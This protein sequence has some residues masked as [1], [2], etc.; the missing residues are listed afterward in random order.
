M[1]AE[2]LDIPKL[3]KEWLI[4][5]LDWSYSLKRKLKFADKIIVV[6]PNLIDELAP[7]VENQEKFVF[8]PNGVDLDLFKPADD[9]ANLRHKL[10]LPER[11]PVIGVVGSML[12]YHIESPIINA[13]EL[14]VKQ[15]PELICLFVG[16]GPAEE[17]IKKKVAKSKATKNIR[18]IGRVPVEQSAKY[19]ATLDV[20]LAWS[21][22]ESAINGWPMRISAY[23]ACGVP[24]VAPDWGCYQYCKNKGSLLTASDGTAKA[25]AE[26]TAKILNNPE[27]A[28]KIGKRARTWAEDELSWKEIT[29]KTEKIIMGIRRG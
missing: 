26:T 13:I 6:S 11:T 24:T 9:K 3:S 10:D 7:K 15:F 21:T 28:C 18:I 17:Q 25:I 12:S 4:T 20:A 5:K 2:M 16:G 22:K 8:L 27:L 29:E 1:R 23:A 14:L 19:I